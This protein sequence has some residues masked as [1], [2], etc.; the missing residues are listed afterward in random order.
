MASFEGM[1]NQEKTEDVP[2]AVLKF[3][4]N[5]GIKSVAELHAKWVEGL[6]KEMFPDN[7]KSAIKNFLIQAGYLPDAKLSEEK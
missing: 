5:K 2:R 3:M 4:K 7:L 1:H 6:C